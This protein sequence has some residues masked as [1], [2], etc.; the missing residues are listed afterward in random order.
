MAK[1]KSNQKQM[2]KTAQDT[3]PVQKIFGNG[4]FQIDEKTFSKAYKFTD[5]NFIT[6]PTTKQNEILDTYQ[7][8]LNRF[9]NSVSIQLVI[10]NRKSTPQELTDSFHLKSKDDGLNEYREDYNK[11]VD[12]KIA[13]GRNDIQKDKY[14]ILSVTGYDYPSALSYFNSLDV[15]INESMQKLNRV[16]VEKV[17]DYERLKIMHYL[18]HGNTQISFDAQYE[19]YKKEDSL[20][21]EELKKAGITIQN[22]VAPAFVGTLPKQRLQLDT[23]RYCQSYMF[24]DLPISLDTKF[25]SEISNIPCEMVTSVLFSS[26]PRNKAVKMIKNQNNSIKADVIKQSQSALKDGYD[27]SLINE[28]LQ[29]AKEES[30]QIRKDVVVEGKKIFFA[31]I[32]NTFFAKSTDELCDFNNN[33]MMKCGDFGLN[34]YNLYEQQIEGLQQ[35][36]LTGK[37]YVYLDRMITSDSACALFPFNIQEMMDKGGHFYGINAVSKN[38]IMYNRRTSDLPNGII[39]GKSGSGKSFITK[40]EII[41]NIL[42][43]EDDIIIL[44]PDG[45]YVPIANEFGGTVIDLRTKGD[46]H[47]NPCDMSMEFDDPKADP[48]AEKCD[49]MVGIVDSILGSRRECNSFEVNAIHRATKKMYEPYIRHMEELHEAGSKIDLDSDACPTLENFYEE[50]INDNT[51]EATK[52]AMSCEPYCV[53]NYN[54]FAHKTNVEGRP[55]FLVYNLKNLPNKMKEMAMKV[56]LSNIWTRV[57]ENKEMKK[58]TWVYLDEFYLLCQTEGSATTLQTYFKRIRKYFGIMTGIT[59]DIQDLLI[60]QQGQGMISNAGFFLMMNQSAIGR[61]NLQKMFEISDA[62]L[63]YIKDKPPGNGLI[64]NGK[65]L[66][67][68]DY[69]LPTDTKLYK[70]M[71]TKPSDD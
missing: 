66:V 24:H 41:P 50:L 12:T 28:D 10:V 16:G 51:P 25:L 3:V 22:I 52:I 29:N 21:L 70:L 69:K 6:E 36:L 56:C 58:A 64:Y 32:T 20:N 37:K 44:D 17:G 57:C 35:N 2:I 65:T 4:I 61:A 43:G 9:Q 54:L 13:D 42:D 38:M 7:Q 68:F 23:E 8:F 48:L 47:I 11:I 31:T 49:F 71:S 55:R 19:R 30:A 27:P 14:I 5:V 1:S 59:Q 39:L 33:F 45:E 26:I 60:T 34:P 53:G 46:L 62:L 15:E 18:T 67:P 40:G 63:D